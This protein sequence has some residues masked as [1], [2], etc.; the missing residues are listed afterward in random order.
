MAVAT[1]LSKHLAAIGKKG[2]EAK[3][4]TKVRGD[5]EYY[6][7]IGKK[8]AAAKAKKAKQRDGQ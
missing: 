1:E 3:G 7:R 6:S 5:A 2:G 8:A 4:K